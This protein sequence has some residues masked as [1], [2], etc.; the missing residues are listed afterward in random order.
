MKKAVSLLLS[1]VILMGFAA[2]PAAAQDNQPPIVGDV[3]GD[4][5]VTIFDATFLQRHLLGIEL[6]FTYNALTADADEDGD[7]TIID[8]TNIQRWLLDTGNRLNIG[9]YAF[10][11]FDS[12]TAFRDNENQMTEHSRS[13]GSVSGAFLPILWNTVP[14]SNSK[15]S[16]PTIGASAIRYTASLTTSVLTSSS[17]RRR[18]PTW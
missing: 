3:D 13:S 1:L 7:V 5:T 12:S 15:A 6:P 17:M 11:W 8:A 14:S 10:E 16:S 4:Q 18:K 9:D 2:V